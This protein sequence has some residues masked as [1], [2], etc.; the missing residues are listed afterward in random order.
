MIIIIRF[1]KPSFANKKTAFDSF[2]VSWFI[3]SFF[4]NL[5][6]AKIYLFFYFSFNYFLFCIYVYVC[7][8]QV[9]EHCI[10]TFINN[11]FA[12]ENHSH[13]SCANLLL[14]F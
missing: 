3:D 5:L 12:F 11:L 1:I 13:A 4:F 9:N 8:A 2:S 10:P 7:I 6:A 14:F